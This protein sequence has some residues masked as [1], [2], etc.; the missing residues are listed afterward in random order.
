MTASDRDLR[1]TLN[2]IRRQVNAA[3]DGPWAPWLD[4]DGTPH[5]NGL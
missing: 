3:T 2:R 1:E 5:M 4:Q